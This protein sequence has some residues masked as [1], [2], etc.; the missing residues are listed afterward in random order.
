MSATAV[1]KATISGN[2]ITVSFPDQPDF[3]FHVL[4][5][6][7]RCQCSLC[8]HE[9]SK[10][11]ILTAAEV[12]AD[13]RAGEVEFSAHELKIVW[14]DGHASRYDA[15]FL[16]ESTATGRARNKHEPILWDANLTEDFPQVSFD[17]VM[18]SDTAHLEMLKLMVD[19]GT[20]RVTGVSTEEERTEEL[21][22]KVSIVRETPHGKIYDVRTLPNVHNLAY[23]SDALSVHVDGPYHYYSPGPMLFHFIEVTPTGGETVL[24]D[25]FK[26]ARV[27]QVENPAGFDLLCRLPW[28]NAY[29]NAGMDFRAAFPPI[30]I[31]ADGDLTYFALNQYTSFPEHFEADE[32]EDAY[33][34]WR[35]I[36]EIATRPELSVRFKMAAGDGLF[37]DNRR[38]LHT[39]TAFDPM[40]GPRRLRTCYM[41]R[42]TMHSNLRVLAAKLG[43]PVRNAVFSTV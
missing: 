5:L 21:A 17:E 10:Q 8:I 37:F 41:D 40:S 4:W 31:N 1:V 32:I 9:E 24:V 23:G 38:V 33:A 18:Q 15:A 6:R 16:A 19:Y 27:M 30:G 29:W 12:P 13:I 22:S 11:K 25:G 28:R 35:Q 43:D 34:A 26:V 36:N 14:S 39:R 3:D 20:V 2:R 42:D 7:D